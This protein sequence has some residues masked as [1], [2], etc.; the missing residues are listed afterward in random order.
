VSNAAGHEFVIAAYD[1]DGSLAGLAT[2]INSLVGGQLVYRAERFATREHAERR[3]PVVEKSWSAD[4]LWCVEPAPAQ[5]EVGGKQA[6][7]DKRPTLDK[8]PHDM[9]VSAASAV[10]ASAEDSSQRST[11]DRGAN[12]TVKGKTK[13]AK[14]K[15]KDK[16]TARAEKSAPAPKLGKPVMRTTAAKTVSA[17]NGDGGRPRV[18]LCLCNC[19]EL[20][21]NWL[22]RGHWR[23]FEAQLR[24][25]KNGEAAPEKLFGAKIAKAMGPWVAVGKLGGKKP[26]TVNY[27][28]IREALA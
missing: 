1:H 27:E 17:A 10:A 22:K 23:R 8:R 25:I 21:S 6:A 20:S 5:D 3:L 2:S 15:A 19:G 14:G 13:A 4:Y 9:P 11:D 16:K 12:M 28:V 7:T 18:G 24:R 26:K